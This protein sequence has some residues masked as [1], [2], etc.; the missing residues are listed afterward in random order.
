[1]KTIMKIVVCN[2]PKITATVTHSWEGYSVHV[3]CTEHSGAIYPT[4]PAESY[5]H[6]RRKNV[7]WDE[8]PEEIK[9][10]GRTAVLTGFYG[11]YSVLTPH[12]IRLLDIRPDFSYLREAIIK[13]IENVD[14][15]YLTEIA[16]GIGKIPFSKDGI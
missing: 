11:Y 1:M 4:D 7:S 16:L 15:G 14:D 6:L 10:E 8:V 2:C 9:E 3:N 5:K 13:R 12:A